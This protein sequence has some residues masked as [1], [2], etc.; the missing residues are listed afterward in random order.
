[1]GC[2]TGRFDALVVV[3]LFHKSLTISAAI[4]GRPVLRISAVGEVLLAPL[5]REVFCLKALRKLSMVVSNGAVL[6]FPFL[7]FI[8]EVLVKK[9]SREPTPTV[10]PACAL[11]T[12][13]VIF[14]GTTLAVHPLR[15]VD[16]PD[17]FP[18]LGEEGGFFLLRITMLLLMLVVLPLDTTTEWDT[19]ML[20]LSVLSTVS[21]SAI[22]ETIK[23]RSAI[24]IV[25]HV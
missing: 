13:S 14:V 15:R 16:T 23:I 7:S 1:M 6:F 25:H 17:S 11:L 21:G 8:P 22:A 19:M 2:V 24:N 5:P 9:S 10:A 20:P 12:S 4:P 3:V 18:V